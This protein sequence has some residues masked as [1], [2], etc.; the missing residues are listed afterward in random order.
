MKAYIHTKARRADG[1]FDSFA[2]I[3]V[4][5]KESPLWWQE[6]GLSYTASG[7]GARIPTRYMVKFN[8]RWLRVYCRIYSNNGTMYI[9][10]LDSDNPCF[11]QIERD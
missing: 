7:Y 6:N 3:G 1:S 4:D 9:G 11:V 5:C 10:K 2:T 8:D